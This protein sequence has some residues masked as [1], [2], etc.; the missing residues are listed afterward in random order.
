VRHG[1]QLSISNNIIFMKTSTN[2]KWSILYLSFFVFSPLSVLIW[3]NLELSSELIINEIF[4]F[5]RGYSVCVILFILFYSQFYVLI[6]VDIKSISFYFP[7]RIVFRNYKIYFNEISEFEYFFFRSSTLDFIL[8]GSGKSIKV[9][10]MLFDKKGNDA[11]IRLIEDGIANK[12][13]SNS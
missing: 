9:G 11:V 7:F 13:E 3:N 10:Y 2:L 8:S 6:K 12:V 5:Y 4:K 1:I